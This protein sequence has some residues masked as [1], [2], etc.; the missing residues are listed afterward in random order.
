MALVLADRVRE[1]TTTTGT[2]SVTLAGAYTGF[3]TFSA[4]IGNTNSTYYT[5]ANVGSGEWEVGIGTYSSG[6]NL[7]SRTTVLSSSNG[8]SLVNFGAGAKDV[9]VTQPA[10]RALYVASAGTGLE[11]QVTAFTNGGIVYASSTSALAT[12]SALTFDGTTL[13]HTGASNFATSTGNVGIGT[14]SPSVKLHASTSGAGI[15]EVEWLNNSQAVGADVGSAMVFTGTSS[16]NGLARLS[17][18]FAGATTADGAYM[19]FSTRAVTSGAL[20][21]RMRL[22][23]SGNLGLGVTPSA[24]SA[25]KGLQV[26]N[27]GFYGFSTNISG[28]TANCYYNSGWK[29]IASSATA[30]QYEQSNG[31]H[32]WYQAPSGTAGNAITFTQAMTLNASGRLGIGET[33]P[34]FK[35]DVSGTSDV[36]SIRSSASGQVLRLS[37]SSANPLIMRMEN[38]SSNFWDTQVNTDNSIS[39]DYNDSEKARIDSSGNLLVGDTT[40]IGTGGKLQVKSNLDTSIF[41]CTSATTYAA[42]VSNVEN[43]A[44]RLI[45]FQYGSGGSPTNV[46]RITTD[47]TNIA[48]ATVSGITFPATQAASADANTL[49]DYEEGTW[50]PID[51]S[52]A[53]LSFTISGTSTYTKIGQQVIC[54]AT[55]TYPTTASGSNAVIGGLPFATGSNGPGSGQMFVSATNAA[56]TIQGGYVPSASTLVTFAGPAG[57]LVSNASMSAAVVYF[58]VIYS[59]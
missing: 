27:A 44:A 4:A 38:N 6:G 14:N 29:Y 8:G 18:A 35:L 10:E 36:A 42:I 51:S 24:W 46:G 15:Q 48:I 9:F 57:G 1:T 37:Q 59:T 28:V 30:T 20:T 11:S 52:G 21:E 56:V 22:D 25:V 17:G 39:W 32:I 19:A 2:G 49:D 7:L 54:R 47:G 23:S 41:K 3:Q 16:N 43:T 31:S 26:L 13:Q 45:A 53:G 33:N 40:T 50:T 5:I 12:G 55:L 34:T 58:T